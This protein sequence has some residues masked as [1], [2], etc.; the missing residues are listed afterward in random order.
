LAAPPSPGPGFPLTTDHIDPSRAREALNS[1]YD[2]LSPQ[3][4]LWDSIQATILGFF[5]WIMDFVG[6]LVA[7]RSGVGL[8]L[9]WLAVAA[10]TGAVLWAAVWLLRRVGIVKV[11]SARSKQVAP[12]PVD[13]QAA[14]DAALARGDLVEATRALYRELLVTLMERG[15]L[16]DRPG[17]TAGDARRAARRVPGLYAEIESATSAF[18]NVA[19]GK[20]YADEAG[21]ESLK[22]ARSLVAASPGPDS[23]GGAS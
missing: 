8:V 7:G 21:I 12:P 1:A 10:L 2:G 17:L 9:G 23:H 11:S 18:E 16:T 15:F 20:R 5:A 14:A 19:F 4:G 6:G 3:P 13:W 22:R